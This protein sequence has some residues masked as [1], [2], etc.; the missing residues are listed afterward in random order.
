MKRSRKVAIILCCFAFC[1]TAAIVHR[2]LEMRRANVRPAE[3]YETVWK[4][5]S[6]F[7]DAD[8]AHASQQVSASFQERFNI[9]AFAELARTDYAGILRAERVEFGA[10]RTEGRHAFVHVY[11]FL[12]G[13]EVI[14]CVYS[15]VYEESGW[16]IDGARPQKRWPPGRRMGGLRS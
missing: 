5:V 11:F 16:K 3:L 12:P 4:Q 8:F 9:E 2:T 10:V 14:P 7:R 1:G 15:L 6:A 13:G